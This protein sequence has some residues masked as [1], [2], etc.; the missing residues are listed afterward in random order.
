MQQLDVFPYEERVWTQIDVEANNKFGYVRTFK[1]DGIGK[2][3]YRGEGSS[4]TPAF[5]AKLA[6]PKRGAASQT[7][8]AR[9]KANSLLGGDGGID[10]DAPP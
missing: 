8:A 7:D 3:V 5:L 9:K 2:S 4:P 10:W 1:A 6:T